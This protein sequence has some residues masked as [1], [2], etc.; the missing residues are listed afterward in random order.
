M[1]VVECGAINPASPPV[2]IA[3]A[4]AA[5]ISLRIRGELDAPQ[6]PAIATGGLASLIAPHSRTIATIDPELTLQ[7]LRLV[8]ELNR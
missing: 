4:S 8:W 6:T 2:A 5:P 3:G 1:I 7:G